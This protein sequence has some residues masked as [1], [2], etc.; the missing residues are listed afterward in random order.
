MTTF[1]L[2]LVILITIIT[3]S[4]IGICF[5]L[6]A[7]IMYY[8]GW[9]EGRWYQDIARP[10]DARKLLL[11][12]IYL[13]IENSWKD[14]K[15]NYR[16]ARLVYLAGRISASE[17]GLL[18]GTRMRLIRAKAMLAILLNRW[19]PGGRTDVLLLEFD[20]FKHEKLIGCVTLVA[21]NWK[22]I[23]TSKNIFDIHVS[24]SEASNI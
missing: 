1:E 5:S 10:Q 7:Q 21:I 15:E 8:K 2:T 16:R 3:S 19:R 4:S 22:E 17:S 23:S 11:I 14:R 6:I 24:I 13:W 12:P 18:P 20:S 9:Q